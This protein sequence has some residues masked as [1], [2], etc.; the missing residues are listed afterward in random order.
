[1]KSNFFSSTLIGTSIIAT[2]LGTV[3]ASPVDAFVITNTSGSWDNALLSN[4]KVV[5]SNGEQAGP[6]NDVIFQQ[7]GTDA[8]VRWGD[9]V[10]GQWEKWA[11]NQN[12]YNAG[13]KAKKGWYTNAHGQRV[14]GWYNYDYVSRYEDKSGLGFE[15]VSNLSISAGE[16]FNIGSLTHFNQTIW[17]NGKDAVSTDFSLD[18]NFSDPNIGDQTFNFAFSID[19]TLNSAAVC[20]YQTDA[21]KGCSD[22]IT[23]D[24][25]I[26]ESSSFMYN[27]EE[28]TLELMGFSE[29][30]AAASIVNE[31]I[32]Q[33]DGNN[34]A[35]LFA[36]LI[37][38]DDSKDIPEPASLLGLL[39]LSLFV[40]QSRQQ[41]NSQTEA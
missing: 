6:R 18:L 41:R 26:D 8:Q 12:D 11:F 15:G 31:F 39:G 23:W 40:V 30:V 9:S 25:S 10:N 32:S 19:E 5:G 34:S 2:T 4:G 33:E 24:W 38:V 28:Y 20:E 7:N 35:G 17:L 22:K 37:A 27:G 13:Y 16:I 1:M 36:R 29:R 14:H 21:G 3:A